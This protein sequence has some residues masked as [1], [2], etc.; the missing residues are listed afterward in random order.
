[1]F[2]LA[3]FHFRESHMHQS[4]GIWSLAGNYKYLR[5]E[6]RYCVLIC[7]MEELLLC[8]YRLHVFLDLGCDDAATVAALQC[9][10]TIFL[11]VGDW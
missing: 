2:R 1:M 7:W 4:E 5:D 11:A 9:V 10:L 3:L 6:S 8:S